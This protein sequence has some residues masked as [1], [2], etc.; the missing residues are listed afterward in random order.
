MNQAG[1]NSMVSQ[2]WTNYSSLNENRDWESGENWIR[3]S[4]SLEKLNRCSLRYV[5]YHHV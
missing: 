5:N 3:V 2:K 4:R 1:K